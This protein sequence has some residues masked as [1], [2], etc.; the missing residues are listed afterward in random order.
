MSQNSEP[1]R[2]EDPLL[3]LI[4]QGIS[5]IRGDDELDETL[6]AIRDARSDKPKDDSRQ[7]QPHQTRRNLLFRR[8][9]P[10]SVI[11]NLLDLY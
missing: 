9:F 10:S 4:D 1:I 5:E 6:S 7:S 11:A 8:F 2:Y 3:R